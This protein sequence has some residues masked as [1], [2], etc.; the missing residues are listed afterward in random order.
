MVEVSTALPCELVELP[1]VSNHVSSSTD[2]VHVLDAE[3]TAWSGWRAGES[4]SVCNTTLSR[5]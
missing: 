3:S 4:R 5:T 2:R 1:V